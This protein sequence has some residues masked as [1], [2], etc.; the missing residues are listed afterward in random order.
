MKNFPFF[1]VKKCR[2][3]SYVKCKKFINIKNKFFVC[4]LKNIFYLFI[5]GKKESEAHFEQ[6]FSLWDIYV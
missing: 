5:M 3:F 6:S 1:N 4:D 2:L